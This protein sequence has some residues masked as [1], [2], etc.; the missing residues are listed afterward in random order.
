MI[1]FCS[2]SS[3]TFTSLPRLS[4]AESTPQSPESCWLT[5]DTN[6]TAALITHVDTVLLFQGLVQPQAFYVLNEVTKRKRT[7]QRRALCAR[8]LYDHRLPRLY[9]Y[10]SVQFSNISSLSW[11]QEEEGTMFQVLRR[12]GLQVVQQMKKA[13]PLQLGVSAIQR[14]K[15]LTTWQLVCS[16][17]WQHHQSGTMHYECT[18]SQSPSCHTPSLRKDAYIIKVHKCV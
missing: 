9:F 17:S 4:L 10:Y 14:N 8:C 6:L 18:H 5:F 7:E 1:H 11:M 15:N 16:V 12:S 2:W 3:F 13:S